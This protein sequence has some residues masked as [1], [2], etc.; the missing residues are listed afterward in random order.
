MSATRKRLVAGTQLP[1][2]TPAT[3]GS[4][5]PANARFFITAMALT[6]TSGGAVT[7]TVHL[8]TAAAANC[9]M[10]ARSIAA[11]ETVLVTGAIGQVMEAGEVIQ[12]A[13]SAATSIS[14]VASGIEFV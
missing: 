9:V 8:G 14:M 13:A 4:A 3:I 5:I 10:S 11:G 12:A 1:L 7:A 6:N 2:T